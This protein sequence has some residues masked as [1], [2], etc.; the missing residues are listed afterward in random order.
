MYKVEG[1]GGR[2]E[3]KRRDDEGG[4][5]LRSTV[6]EALEEIAGGQVLIH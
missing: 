5:I 2:R 6:V 1:Y 4:N 3:N